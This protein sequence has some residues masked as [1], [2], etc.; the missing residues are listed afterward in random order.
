M[1]VCIPEIRNTIRMF[2]CAGKIDGRAE[3]G[4][5]KVAQGVRAEHDRIADPGTGDPFEVQQ[6]RLGG[7]GKQYFH[8]YANGKICTQHFYANLILLFVEKTN[9]RVEGRSG[10]IKSRSGQIWGE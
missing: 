2:D 10:E 3:G 1:D 5:E 8:N 7:D 6:E 9:R 4:V